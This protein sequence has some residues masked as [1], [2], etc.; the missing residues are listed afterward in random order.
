MMKC[1]KCGEEIA[2]RSSSMYPICPQ[3]DKGTL[4][5][6]QMKDG[7]NV[8]GCTHCWAVFKL[9]G[10]TSIDKWIARWDT[11]ED[12]REDIRRSDEIKKKYR[13]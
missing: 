6:F 2:I 4:L 11:W 9:E 13:E 8:Y 7:Y 10:T 3:C 1:P 12:L 5:P